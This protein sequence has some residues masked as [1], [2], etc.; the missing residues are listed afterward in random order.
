MQHSTFD[1]A[2]QMIK[3]YKETKKKYIYKREPK[4][5]KNAAVDCKY[6]TRSVKWSDVFLFEGHF[7][8]GRKLT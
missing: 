6:V 8:Y 3:F 4:R 5:M 1:I 2:F 7:I